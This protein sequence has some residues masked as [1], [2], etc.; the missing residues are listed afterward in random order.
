VNTVLRKRL[1]KGTISCIA[2]GNLAFPQKICYVK[3][4]WPA[5]SFCYAFFENLQPHPRLCQR[6]IPDK[7]PLSV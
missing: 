1:Q 3:S 2:I 6:L 4:V 7:W 5:A